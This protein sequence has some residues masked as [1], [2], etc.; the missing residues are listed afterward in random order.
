MNGH[1]LGE[2]RAWVLHYLAQ[3]CNKL[4]NTCQALEA[5]DQAIELDPGIIELYSIKSKV[6]KKAGNLKGKATFHGA[7]VIGYKWLHW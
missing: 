2:E 7:L 1:N 5:I 6:L 3:H 4:G